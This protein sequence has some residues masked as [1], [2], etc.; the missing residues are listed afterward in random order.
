ITNVSVAEAPV[1]TSIPVRPNRPLNVLLG[2]FLGALLSLG[3]VVVAEFARDTVLTPH[4]LELLTGRP[5][6]A[7]LPK[8]AAREFTES[9]FNEE[10]LSSRLVK[11]KIGN[12][13]Q[14]EWAD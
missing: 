5:V 12:E 4:E 7:S 13:P 11:P 14:F 6:L 9:A 1:Q 2:L 8:N 3:S 10:P